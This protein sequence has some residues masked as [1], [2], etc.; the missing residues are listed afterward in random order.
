MSADRRASILNDTDAFF[1]IAGNPEADGS[2][3]LHALGV[4]GRLKVSKYAPMIEREAT[5]AGI[6]P[7]LVKAIM[8][9]EYSQGALYGW[10]GEEL[11]LS[12]SLYPMN[13]RARDWSGLAPQGADFNDPEQN[14]RAGVTLLRRI[15]DRLGDPAVRKIASLYNFIGAE[16]VSDYGARV[17]QVYEEKP[18]EEKRWQMGPIPELDLLKRLRRYV[19]PMPPEYIPYPR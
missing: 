2:E 14:I 12:E 18:W 16:K 1:P 19:T 17:G 15:K 9:V 10:P 6:D 13:I 7:D 3:P 4:L 11:G 5:R 8:Y